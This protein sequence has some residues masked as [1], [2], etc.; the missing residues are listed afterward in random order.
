MTSA[1]V[2]EPSA[3]RTGGRA[4]FEFTRAGL[5]VSGAEGTRFEIPA[6]PAS[7]VFARATV[8]GFTITSS[9]CSL[10][11]WLM[12]GTLAGAAFEA[13]WT[14]E[15]EGWARFSIRFEGKAAAEWGD[16]QRLVLLDQEIPTAVLR[17]QLGWR[18]LGSSSESALADRPPEEGGGLLP[19]FGY[20]IFGPDF[21]LGAEHPMACIEAD[22]NRA[23]IFHHPL[24]EKN[25]LR[26]INL[27]VGLCREGEP[28]ERAFARY[29]QTIR[30]RRPER[31]IVEINTFWT[32]GFANA[33]KYA[34]QTDPESYLAMAQ[35]WSRDVLAG[36]PGLVSHFLLDAGWQNDAS[37]YRP[38][39][40][41]GGPG[42]ETLARIGREILDEGF[43]FGLWFSVNG[44]I[45]VDPRWA[46]GQG[47]R[48]HDQGTGAGY[49]ANNGKIRYIC[50]TDPRWEDDLSSRL[51]EIISRVPVTF[52]KGDWDNDAIEDPAR[53]GLSK[54]QLREAIANAMIRIY[55]RMHAANPA[56]ALR[57]A[58][59]LSPWWLPH[60]DN[61]HLPNSG[62]ME[63][64]DLPSLTHRDSALT[65]RDA[66]YHHVMV[67]SATPVPWDVL[68]PHEFASSR[69]NPVQ[70]TEDSWMNNL[71]MWSSRGSQYLQLYLAPYG[72]DGWKAWSLREILRWYRSEEELLWKSETRML[73]ADPLSGG[74]YAYLHGDGER[75]LLT[76][77]NPLAHPQALHLSPWGLGETGWQQIYPFCRSFNA[78]GYVMSSHEVLILTRGQSVHG[79]L[80]NT[81]AGWQMPQEVRP[82][83]R[84]EL[85]PVAARFE[86]LGSGKLAIHS[87]LPYGLKSATI[88]LSVEAEAGRDWRAA[89]GRYE[90]D[91]ASFGVPITQVR[92]HWQSGYA[93]GRLPARPQEPS[94]TILRIPVGTGGEAHCFLSSAQEFPKI[95]GGWIEGRDLL[96]PAKQAP[97]GFHPPAMSAPR[98]FLTA[99]EPCGSRG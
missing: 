79:P 67:R 59:W 68:C 70:D 84:H 54:A 57:G 8:A 28:V 76:I 24:W 98:R 46:A 64:C 12:K 55:G 36:E 1:L 23:R 94:R 48:T 75:A 77:R 10:R 69:R 5:R 22:K 14:I 66:V 7:L 81:P 82:P 58:W 21:F 85:P 20:P 30:R 95:L 34:G 2:G 87:S 35:A 61:T 38:Q 18:E 56:V 52:F 45:G 74:I 93:Q 19:P 89:V 16:F 41:N 33:T 13:R 11:N 96:Q 97:A 15:A 62:D 73:G 51:E 43:Q 47:Y 44:P 4:G 86:R 90:E 49:S 32:D 40:E 26:S 91:V 63:P 71:A 27:V 92:P 3:L 72:L 37:L 65:C 78:S 31:A 25:E 39:A 53:P 88:V 83:R 17:D 9:E 6:I 60:V 99:I 42:D 50:L 80:V 29:V